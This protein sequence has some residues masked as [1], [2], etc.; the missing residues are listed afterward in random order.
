M[1]I[2]KNRRS[3]THCSSFAAWA[4]RRWTNG[5]GKP[6]LPH[7]PG[8]RYWVIVLAVTL[9]IITYVDRV[10]SQA[11]R[12][13]GFFAERQADGPGVFGVSRWRIRCSGF[14]GLAG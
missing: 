3:R 9:A 11:E 10:M 12:T 2:Y 7:Q 5:S 1:R 8:P 6:A 13:G 14:H 4:R